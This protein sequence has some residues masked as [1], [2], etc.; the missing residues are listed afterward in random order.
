MAEKRN[1]VASP[2]TILARWDQVEALLNEGLMESFPASDPASISFEPPA[3]VGS[4]QVIPYRR[5]TPLSTCRAAPAIMEPSRASPLMIVER[6]F[7]AFSRL[8]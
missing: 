4:S 7:L 5:S 3:V 6:K 8:I 2:D 1:Q